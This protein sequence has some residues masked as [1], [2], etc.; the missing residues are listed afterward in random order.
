MVCAT[1]VFITSC[2]DDDNDTPTDD[3]DLKYLI[4]TTVKN[5]DG[6]SGASYIQL[7]SEFSGS[8][9]NTNA[10][11][12]GFA[13]P[14]Y[15]VDH[16]VYVFPSFDGSASS[17]QLK[18]YSYT[19]SGMSGPMTLDLPPTSM[20]YNIV[21]VANDKAYLS[22]YALGKLWIINPNTLE[23]TGEID[24]SPYA[25]SDASPEPAYG[26][27]RDGLYY[28]P[29]DQV[30]ANYMPYPDYQQV[31]VAIID[32]AT[33]EVVQVISETTLG[34]TFPTRPFMKNMIFGNE[35]N[36]I[37]IACAGYFGYVP[38]FPKN[39]FVCIPSGQQSFDVSRSWDISQTSI[40][41]TSYTP[42]SVYNCKYIGNGK[43]V[44]YVGIAE[45]N[46]NNPYTAKNSMA[47]LIDLNARTIKKIEGIPLTDGHSVFIDSYN[48]LIVLSVY[49]EQ[50]SGFFTYNPANEEV[51]FVLSTAGNP[52]FF[53]S[54]E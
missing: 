25:H 17:T 41:G 28:L 38:D 43:L 12:I 14:V 35:Q 27:V 13:S 30:G 42:A 2:K 50:Q 40:Q 1:T 21:K 19:P 29:L 37:Y 45:L 51:E 26:Y 46:G 20:M 44:A 11:Q 48:N 34:L 24:L 8:V 7:I 5:S 9:D 39:G 54:F 32:I 18:K 23:K 33:D 36:D 16:N 49:G 10:T 3:N 53:H 4:E 6:L 31:D 52:A 22:G 47:V 15:V